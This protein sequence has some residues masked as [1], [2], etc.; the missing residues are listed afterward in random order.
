M[1]VITQQLFDVSFKRVPF[2]TRY[3][4]MGPELP[5][6]VEVLRSKYGFHLDV[7]GIVSDII[8]ALL[9]G[10]LTP[11]QVPRE[12]S[13]AGIPQGRIDEFI[14]DL[15]ETVFS[16]LHEQIAQ[17]GEEEQAPA[18][19]ITTPTSRREEQWVEVTPRQ[20]SPSQVP[21]PSYTPTPAPSVSAFAR[22]AADTLPAVPPPH[23]LV[24]RNTMPQTPAPRPATTIQEHPPMVPD[25]LSRPAPSPA[26]VPR[27]VPQATPLHTPV[28]SVP[29]PIP[30]A[31]GMPQAYVRTMSADIQAVHEG[32]HP[33]PQPY[34]PPNLPGQEPIAYVPP[35]PA[36]LAPPPP[37]RPAPQVAAV[38]TRPYIPQAPAPAA[39]MPVVKA[40]GDP[41]REPIE[42]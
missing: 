19:D 23:E 36:P 30:P 5:A 9:L 12:L 35:A 13:E 24:A 27:P 1:V 10:I 21:P 42:S 22:Q 34:I 41:Y 31:A 28:R 4:L 32:H 37:P 15:N 18:T 17:E 39:G 29:P 7:A 14:K 6:A 8:T 3:F 25:A 20:I 40:G 38:H 33:E 16:P 26:P 11:P 2:A